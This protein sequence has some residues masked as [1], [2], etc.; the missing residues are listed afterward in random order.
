MATAGYPRSI[1]SPQQCMKLSDGIS[2]FTTPCHYFDYYS[3]GVLLCKLSSS[4]DS[5]LGGFMLS[6][7]TTSSWTEKVSGVHLVR[8]CAKC[9]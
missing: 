1:F 5:A 6:W 8:M 3:C 2:S 4:H 7:F 9:K